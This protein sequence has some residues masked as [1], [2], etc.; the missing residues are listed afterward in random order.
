MGKF[1]S[2]MTEMEELNGGP[3]PE[4]TKKDMPGFEG[5]WEALE[6]LNVEPTDA[7]LV[8]IENLIE[9]EFYLD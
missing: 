6:G 2:I 4:P 3:L 7:E 9:N 1:K 5:T 8:E